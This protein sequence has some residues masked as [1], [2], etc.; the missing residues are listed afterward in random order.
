MKTTL[1]EWQVADAL[2]SDEYARWSYEG[3]KA[4]AE[5]LCEIDEQ[6]GEDT[7]LDVVAIRCDFSEYKSAQEAASNY[8]WQFEGEEESPLEYLY[9]RTQV[10]EFKGGIII[11]NF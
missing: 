11:A 2:K 8:S 5:Y 4:L 9:Y 7:E 6:S 10:I 3:A 1:T